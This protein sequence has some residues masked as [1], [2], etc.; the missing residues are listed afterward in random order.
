M[1]NWNEIQ[2]QL[3]TKK[4]RPLEVKENMEWPGWEQIGKL[5]TPMLS[6]RNPRNIVTNSVSF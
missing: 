6:F 2:N 5:S 4:G 3:R 1:A